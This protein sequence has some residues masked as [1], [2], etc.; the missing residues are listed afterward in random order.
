[1]KTSFCLSL[2][3][4]AAGTLHAQ[5]LRPEAVNGALLG[6]VAGAVIGHN[7]GDLRHNGWKGAAIGAGAGLILGEMVGN[8]RA[9]VAGREIGSP[10][11]A[12]H[13]SFIHRDRPYGYGVA[14]PGIHLD[15]SYRHSNWYG[16]RGYY[17]R[18]YHHRPGYH[19]AVYWPSYS[20]S[21]YPAY[22]DA[23]PYY[24]YGTYG[25]GTPS[26]AGQGLLLGG[27]AGAIIGHN[28]GTFRHDAW[29]GA[30]WGAGAGWLLGAIADARRPQV[31]QS[32]PVVSQ[33]AQ[34]APV[35]AQPQQVTIINNYYNAPATPM[36]GANG[37][38]GRQ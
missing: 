17:G 18:G 14:R 4:L 20:L 23:Y 3:L 30:A 12:A 31:V 7:S 11:S 9:A 29:R 28:S 33:P 37:L 19:G 32:A 15:A 34:A 25:Y 16:H 22:G 13:S 24:D 27:L 36:S 38:F 8:H 21:Y 35:A 26:H 2:G 6:G 5:I 1:M 10:A